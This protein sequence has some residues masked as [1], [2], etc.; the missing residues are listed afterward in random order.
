MSHERPRNHDYWCILRLRTRLRLPNS[1]I[2]QAANSG[3]R[4]V[5]GRP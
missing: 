5:N 2:I 1:F 4:G 3:V